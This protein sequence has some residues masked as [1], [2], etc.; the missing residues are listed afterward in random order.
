MGKYVFDIEGDDLLPK[1]TR[2]WALVTYNLETAEIKHYLEGDKSWMKV[3]DEASLV[4]GHNIYGYDIPVLKKLFNYTLPKSCNVHDTLLMSQILNYRRFGMDGH[5]LDRWGKHLGEFKISFHDFSKY[6]EEMLEYCKQDVVVNLKVYQQLLDEF[7]QL[8][9]V[10]PEI[11]SYMRAEHAAAKWA[12]DAQLNGW[13]FDKEA[14]I[15]LMERLQNERDEINNKLSGVLG[16]KAVII[17]R[18]PN[19]PEG[20]IRA[21]TKSPKWIKNGNYNSHTASWFN[22]DPSAG[23]FSRPIWGDFCRV[24]FKPLELTSVNDVKTFLFR[25]GWK[26]TEWNIKFDEETN[27]KIK[28]SPKITDDSLELLGGDGRLYADFLTISS[29][30]NILKTWLENIDENGNLHGDSMIIGTPSMRTRHQIIVNVPSGDSPYGKEMRELFSCKPGWILIGADSAGNQ[31]RGLAH[32]I[33][34]PEF[35][36]TILNGDIHVYN[37]TKLTEVL[38][39]KLNM[40]YEVTRSNAK[41]IL[42]AFLFGASGG[43]L[44][45]YIFGNLNDKKGKKLKDGFT[46]AVPGFTDLLKKLDR[47]F[48]S[49]KKKGFG[50]IRSLAGN[51]IY[52]DSFHKLLVYL[53][54]SA[55]KITCSSALM[56][57]VQK[58]EEENIPYQPLIFYHDEIDFMVPIEYAERAAEIAASSFKDAPKLY[59]VEIMDGDAKVGK[60]WYEIH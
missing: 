58:L 50:Y 16:S 30:Y 48:G 37:A 14:A 31:A 53:L 26:P 52:V 15:K 1:V 10:K 34:D 5:S 60:N 44:W 33:N 51:R 2:M 49:S 8:K 6:S 46:D 17:D 3:F 36:D 11:V 57:A 23:L 4:V 22:I 45:S 55:E 27:Q 7:A 29:R 35:T 28:T 39:E 20:G 18:I 12:M 9:G 32:Y 56:L 42:Y 25:N 54:Q 38:K 43:K 47:E 41:R 19:A 40:D 24:D 59:G 21:V 13:P